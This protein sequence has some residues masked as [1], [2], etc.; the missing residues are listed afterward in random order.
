MVFRIDA[1]RL[2]D[3]IDCF[4]IDQNL[5]TFSITDKKCMV[6]PFYCCIVDESFDIAGRLMTISDPCRVMAVILQYHLQS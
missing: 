5:R 1:S 6:I 3:H 2:V 4:T